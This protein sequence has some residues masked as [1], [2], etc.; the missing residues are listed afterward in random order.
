MLDR[1]WDSSK[2]KADTLPNPAI[3]ITSL[4]KRE[5]NDQSAFPPPSST[6]TS[7]GHDTLFPSLN[8]RYALITTVTSVP[9]SS[10]SNVVTSTFYNETTAV[11]TTSVPT[12]LATEFSVPAT[13]TS[14]ST[15]DI[16]AENGQVGCYS[17]CI[18]PDAVCCG[19]GSG[20]YCPSG[21]YCVPNGCCP[22][23]QECNGGG[24][25][26]TETGALSTT[27]NSGAFSTATSVASS[28]A[29]SGTSSGLFPTGKRMQLQC[30][31]MT[32]ES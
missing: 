25:T 18:P 17:T 1:Q 2:P 16:C 31:L 4:G 29:T 12:S 27:T 9:D 7:L 14:N 5:Q 8:R 26:I 30:Q 28:T 6:L 10:Y 22:N 3:P 32:R 23:G 13:S 20:T 19:D 15:V 11:T 21:E 24:G